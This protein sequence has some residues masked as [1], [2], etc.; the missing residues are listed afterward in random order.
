MKHWSLILAAI[1]LLVSCTGMV[2]DANTDSG[3][4]GDDLSD[5]LPVCV[6]DFED[7]KGRPEELTRLFIISDVLEDSPVLI[8][9]KTPTS[10]V[11]VKLTPT[12]NRFFAVVSIFCADGNYA[13][14]SENTLF[15]CG[16][17]HVYSGW[18]QI[19]EDRGTFQEAP[20]DTAS[21][22]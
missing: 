2:E 22:R 5:T 10:R 11:Q 15:F 7:S 4:E 1:A 19:R 14:F 17:E 20:D 12:V 16:K 18:N 3:S 21:D 13:V 9:P 8:E 6:F